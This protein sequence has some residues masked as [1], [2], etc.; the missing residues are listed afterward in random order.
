MFILCA[1][2]DRVLRLW[3]V[4]SHEAP[5]AVT[6]P[7]LARNNAERLILY[8]ASYEVTTVCCLDSIWRA[9]APSQRLIRTHRSSDRFSEGDYPVLGVDRHCAQLSPLHVH[10]HARNNLRR[11]TFCVHRVFGVELNECSTSIAD[12]VTRAPMGWTTIRVFLP[13]PLTRSAETTQ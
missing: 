1:W 12:V 9:R 13:A 3:L 2:V 10:V 5:P 6:T 11:G 8:G 7:L 4:K